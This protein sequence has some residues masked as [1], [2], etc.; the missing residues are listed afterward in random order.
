MSDSDSDTESEAFRPTRRNNALATKKR[1]IRDSSSH[2]SD[3]SDHSGSQSDS[4]TS[5]DTASTDVDDDDDDD[6][7]SG[8][9]ASESDGD[10]SPVQKL[11]S[12]KRTRRLPDSSS[13]E[14]TGRRAAST[15][16]S[17][18][19]VQR[20]PAARPYIYD[21]DSESSDSSWDP[22]VGPVPGHRI[23]VRHSAGHRA[24]LASGSRN[25]TDPQPSTSAAARRNDAL[26]AAAAAAATSAAGSSNSA[27]APSSE[28]DNTVD[29]CPICLHSFRDQPLG[30]PNACEHRYC[31]SCIEEW[32]RNVQT[33]PIDRLP[34]TS[35]AHYE[36]GRLVSRIPVEART[37]ELMVFD[38]GDLTQCEV[39]RATNREESMLL[40]D[41]CNRG[42]HMDCLRPA[43]TE[44][45]DSAWYC[46]N[47]FDSDGFDDEHDNLAHL[48][49][50]L[51]QIGVPPTRLRVRAASLG[52]VA[53]TSALTPRITRTRQSE[54]IRA[55]IL[56]RIAPSL[57]HATLGSR[58]SA[59]GMPL[60]GRCPA[61][62]SLKSIYVLTRYAFFLLFCRTVDT[63]IGSQHP[64]TNDDNP[65]Q[66]RPVGA[67][68]PQ[69][70]QLQAQNEEAHNACRRVRERRRRSEV[71]ADNG[72]ETGGHQAQA[73][74]HQTQGEKDESTT[75]L[76]D[77][78]GHAHAELQQRSRC[79]RCGDGR[80]SGYLRPQS[81]SGAAA[82]PVRRSECARLFL[83]RAER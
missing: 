16:G 40:C 60:P 42:Y 59:L 12:A 34:F 15:S 36:G 72:Q 61:F 73:K 14:S 31:L 2:S 28:D 37:T 69:A 20:R 65:E 7:K 51:Q 50:E 9:S 71:P 27:D 45:P 39:C 17:D 62:L 4:N 23:S 80:H 8:T 6:D 30:V 18:V 74:N 64:D 83:G 81:R 19:A 76:F 52:A 25:S 13:A 79:D 44:I 35:I 41:G 43:L 48:L 24:G 63:T 53:S 3:T 82:A 38:D 10:G 57:R 75:R 66:H 11:P 70:A 67:V 29:K 1:E 32:A 33:C 58:E 46:D 56:S 77:A 78:H 22:N 55:T 5:W 54:R 68:T 47:C 21:D 26:A 49:N